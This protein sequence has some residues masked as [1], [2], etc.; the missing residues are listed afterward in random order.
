MEAQLLQLLADT[1][2]TAEAPRKQAEAHLEQLQSNE[3]FP[4]SLGTIA[5]H[6]SVSLAIRQSALSVLRRYVE[7]NW[8]G[9]NE[10]GPTI[11][12]PDPVKA[13]LRN[14]LLEIATSN[15]N[16]RKVRAAARYVTPPCELPISS[17]NEL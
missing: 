12:I 2:S 4:T 10:E 3:T 15:E 9:Q 5:S 16:D 7:Q 14:Q 13:Q 8:S 17:R 1:Q 6:S 11:A